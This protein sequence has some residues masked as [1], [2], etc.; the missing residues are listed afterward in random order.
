MQKLTNDVK[1]AMSEAKIN[2]PL[3]NMISSG[4]P[5]Q[6]DTMAEFMDEHKACYICGKMHKRK[7]L[8]TCNDRCEEAYRGN[9]TLREEILK[10]KQSSKEGT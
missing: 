4:I 5:G 8:K 1:E 9:K 6:T 7:G 2:A 10:E 3:F